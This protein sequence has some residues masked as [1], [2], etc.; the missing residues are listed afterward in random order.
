MDADKKFRVTDLLLG[1]TSV[2]SP[3]GMHYVCADWDNVPIEM[4]MMKAGQVLFGKYHFGNCYIMQTGRGFHLLNFSNKIPL[5]QYITIMKE[6]EC[7]RNYIAWVEKV[8]Y[9]VLRISRR[10]P[11]FS[12]P[13][14]SRI[15][16]SPYRV[17][18]DESRKHMYFAS[19]GFETNYKSV[20]RV[21]VYK[22]PRIRDK[23]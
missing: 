1:I 2:A 4:V 13:V 10:T 3:V 12:I 23:E 14:L 9:G 15:L 5:E 11:H 17:P 6:L 21:K 18:E 7:D 19:L 16:L 8:G 20:R 22:S